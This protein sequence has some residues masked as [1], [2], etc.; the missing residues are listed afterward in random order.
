MGDLYE[1]AKVWYLGCLGGIE[2]R[3]ITLGLRPSRSDIRG[4]RWVC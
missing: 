2:F 4:S 1:V 3:V